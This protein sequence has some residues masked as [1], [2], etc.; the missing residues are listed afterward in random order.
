MRSLS[1]G[2]ELARRRRGHEGGTRRCNAAAAVS[3]TIHVRA[4]IDKGVRAYG[5]VRH[6]LLVLRN[7]LIHVDRR[8]LLAV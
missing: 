2:S 3:S 1:T 7:C 5:H 6:D 8:N 4:P